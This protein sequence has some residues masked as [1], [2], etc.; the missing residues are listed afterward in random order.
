MSTE[1]K[2]CFDFSEDASLFKKQLARQLREASRLLAQPLEDDEL[3]FLNAAGVS[4]RAPNEEEF[5]FG[6][7]DSPR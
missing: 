3:E 7:P 4:H 2:S 5:P 6:S 1:I